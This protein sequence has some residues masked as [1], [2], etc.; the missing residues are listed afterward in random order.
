MSN[1][2]LPLV[3]LPSS[4]PRVDIP[5]HDSGLVGITPDSSVNPQT[6]STLDRLINHKCFGHYFPIIHD[7][8]DADERTWSL[9]LFLRTSNRGSELFIKHHRTIYDSPPPDIFEMITQIRTD[10]SWPTTK[11]GVL[12]RMNSASRQSRSSWP[13]SYGSAHTS[14]SGIH[15]T[16]ASASARSRSRESQSRYS[17]APGVDQPSSPYTQSS[18]RTESNYGDKPTPAEGHSHLPVLGAGRTAP[19]GYRFVC[20]SQ[21]CR[22][23]Y[24][25][26]GD[27][28][29]HMRQWHAEWPAHDA[30]YSLCRMRQDANLVPEAS[31]E[32]GDMAVSANTTSPTTPQPRFATARPHTPAPISPEPPNDPIS[33]PYP[34]AVFSE[35]VGA[36]G[37]DI[38]FPIQH[39]I[40]ATISPPASQSNYTPYGVHFNF[41]DGQNPFFPTQQNQ[42][43]TNPNQPY[44][45]SDS[46]MEGG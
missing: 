20:P 10:K 11:Q 18:H 5:P 21:N 28:N 43:H 13:A 22:K 8:F 27:Y 26:V 4:R 25:R 14:A 7:C 46:F 37:Q 9:L 2:P 15:L 17:S 24:S 41:P 38:P 44:F 16:P 34:D 29:N 12:L 39:F 3:N 31:D 30:Q 45:S 33:T 19:K 36:M 1:K 42:P 6:Q 35:V 32:H 40:D 23:P